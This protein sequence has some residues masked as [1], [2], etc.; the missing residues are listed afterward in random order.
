MPGRNI[1]HGE[2]EQDHFVYSANPLPTWAILIA[3]IAGIAIVVGGTFLFL[4]AKTTE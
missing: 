3:M 4:A 1:K 2:A